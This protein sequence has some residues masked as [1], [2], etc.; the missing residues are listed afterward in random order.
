[1]S[2]ANSKGGV[3]PAS[4]KQEALTSGVKPESILVRVKNVC[5]S[6][7]YQDSTKLYIDGGETKEMKDD[8]WL[9][10]QIAARLIVKV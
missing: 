10:L 2:K 6:R 5:G 8:Y 9:S 1:M 3:K 7:L 4:D